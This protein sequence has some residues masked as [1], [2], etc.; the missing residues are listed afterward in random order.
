MP[1]I[2]IEGD[3]EGFGIVIIEAGYFSVPVI[4][5]KIEGITDA[6]I[7]GIT[8]NLIEAENGQGFIDAIRNNSINRSRI[9]EKTMEAFSW[10]HIGEC[11]INAFNTIASQE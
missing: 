2:K 9:S 8:G 3:Q 7:E 1:N 4:A 5:S 6:V 11:Y 10:N